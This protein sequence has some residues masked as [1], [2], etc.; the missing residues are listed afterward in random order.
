ML[1]EPFP[2]ELLLDAQGVLKVGFQEGR[3]DWWV[4]ERVAGLAQSLRVCF[5]LTDLGSNLPF[6]FSPL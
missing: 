6:K 5:R 2:H 4:S 1:Q 3:G